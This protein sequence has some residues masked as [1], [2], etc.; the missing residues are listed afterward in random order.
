MLSKVSQ[1]SKPCPRGQLNATFEQLFHAGCIQ[2]GADIH[3]DFQIAHHQFAVMFAGL[4]EVTGGNICDGCPAYSQGKCRAFQQ[5]HTGA[6]RY[7]IRT[8]GI[9][10]DLKAT[11]RKPAPS[12]ACVAPG[13]ST[14]PGMSIKQIA[15]EL[16]IS[17]NEVRRRKL[18]GEI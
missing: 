18:R 15:E 13:T 11:R 6:P 12:D 9:T 7:K 16:G 14:H 3:N 1:Q 10:G 5:Y 8:D 2:T 17:K 4:L